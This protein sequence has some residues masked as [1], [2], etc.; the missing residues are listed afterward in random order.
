APGRQRGRRR[1]RPERQ[2]QDDAPAPHRRASRADLR[3]GGSPR[4]PAGHC[5]SSQTHRFRRAGRAPPSVADRAT[6]RDPSAGGEPKR[7][8][9]WSRQSRRVGR[10]DGPERG[11]RRLP[12]SALGRH[13]A[14]SRARAIARHRPRG[15]AHGRAARMTIRRTRVDLAVALLAIVGIAIVLEI[16]SRAFRVPSYL[17]PAPSAVAARMATDAGLLAREGGVTLSEA[18]AGFVLG[19]GVAFALA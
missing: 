16:W 15:A 11:D 10:A 3:H 4:R 14:A 5:P 6:E 12:A 13:A 9:K 18:A 7:A 8:D 19:T 2:R 17:L 1:R